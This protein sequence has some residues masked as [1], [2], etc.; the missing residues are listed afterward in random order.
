MELV[1]K[2]RRENARL[3]TLISPESEA[4]ITRL[5]EFC[6]QLPLEV[7]QARALWIGC[8]MGVVPVQS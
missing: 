2:A 4:D 6:L 5:G 8:A 7:E 3:G 1:A